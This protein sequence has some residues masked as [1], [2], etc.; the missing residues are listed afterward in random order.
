MADSF[1]VQMVIKI[2]A[3]LLGKADNDVLEYEIAGRQLKKT[4]FAD[5]EKM[6]KTYKAE[7][8]REKIKADLDAGLGNFGRKIHTKF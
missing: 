3:V 5:L 2:E 8:K 4:P 6:R 1:A 7:A